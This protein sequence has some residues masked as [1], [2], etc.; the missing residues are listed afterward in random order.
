MQAD[1]A[2]ELEHD[3]TLL[4][5]A[6]PHPD[7]RDHLDDL[8]WWI[9][10]SGSHLDLGYHLDDLIFWIQRSASHLD[11]RDHLDDLKRVFLIAAAAAAPL[12]DELQ[13]CHCRCESG[14][15]GCCGVGVL[16]VHSSSELSGEGGEGGDEDL[17]VNCAPHTKQE[18]HSP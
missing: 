7:L 13:R 17:L 3:S 15:D 12:H 14:S 18:E 9:Q 4:V 6:N 1:V 5:T 8:I 2:I 11:L 10:R 16:L